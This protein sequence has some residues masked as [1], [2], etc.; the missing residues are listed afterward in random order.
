[1]ASDLFLIYFQQM[2]TIYAVHALK[3]DYNSNG[4]FRIP[5]HK[6]TSQ[7]GALSLVKKV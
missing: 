6:C 3:D 2:T 4:I 1:M 5:Q 7:N